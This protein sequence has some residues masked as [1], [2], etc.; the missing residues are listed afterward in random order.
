MRA[1]D[2]GP[3]GTDVWVRAVLASGGSGQFLLIRASLATSAT[4][5]RKIGQ[6][7]QDGKVRIYLCN[8][9]DQSDPVSALSVL[10]EAREAGELAENS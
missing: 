7:P 6:N 5:D 3:A 9:D 10:G 1:P 8:A 4:G 2:A